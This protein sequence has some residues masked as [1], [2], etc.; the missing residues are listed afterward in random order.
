M[1]LKKKQK[2]ILTWIL[3]VSAIILIAIMTDL[4]FA[5][6]GGSISVNCAESTENTWSCSQSG[7]AGVN[8]AVDIV[9]VREPSS[10]STR[11]D[12]ICNKIPNSDGCIAW[13]TYK[14]TDQFS[15]EYQAYNYL[16]AQTDLMVIEGITE[17][18][19]L[20]DIYGFGDTIDQQFKMI[21]PLPD[22]PSIII[23]PTSFTI[24]FKEGG[25]TEDELCSEVG[26]NCPL[27]KTYYR[28]ENNQCNPL[29]LLVSEKKSNDFLT[30]SE[31]ELNILD[32]G[33]GEGDDDGGDDEQEIPEKSNFLL[34]VGFGILFLVVV[35]VL[36][37]KKR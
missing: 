19:R 7:G 8:S 1:K 14:E 10:L 30:L 3:V 23:T 4:P 37:L 24:Y 36:F 22:E 12:M 20:L 27:T 35:M 18:G 2:K 28:F 31:C 9:I 29:V 26:I 21:D 13:Q 34:F 5:I 16:N 6:L 15:Y 32:N 25:Y 17:D 33:N 11:I